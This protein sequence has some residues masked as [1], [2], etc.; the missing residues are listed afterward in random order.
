MLQHI[1]ELRRF[2]ISPR[3]QSDIRSFRM[4]SDL[5]RPS[6]CHDP[7]IKVPAPGP[8]VMRAYIGYML[9]ALNNLEQQEPGYL[10]ARRPTLLSLWIPLQ[11]YAPEMATA[12]L[13]L[14]GRSRNPGRSHRFRRR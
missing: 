8:E 2:P 7:S 10:I 6:L 14:E 11:R 5:M 9:E 4:L 1:G 12:F 3:N 13:N